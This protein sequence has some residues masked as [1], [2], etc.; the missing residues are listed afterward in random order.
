MCHGRWCPWVSLVYVEF[1]S[2]APSK[3]RHGE[4]VRGCHGPCVAPCIVRVSSVDVSRS[5]GQGRTWVCPGF[6]ILSTPSRRTSGSRPSP[7]S[8]VSQAYSYSDKNPRSCVNVYSRTHCPYR[9]TNLCVSSLSIRSLDPTTVGRHPSPRV[10]D[11]GDSC[12]GWEG[13]GVDRR[14]GGTL[15][16]GGFRIST[17]PT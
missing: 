7:V 10:S 4:G 5:H 3:K 2:Q 6:E 1:P 15:I 12:L 13:E 17:H 9:Y 14:G 11:Q 16:E 8:R